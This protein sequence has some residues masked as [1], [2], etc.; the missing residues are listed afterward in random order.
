M[1]CGTGRWAVVVLVVCCFGATMGYA[2][3]ASFTN[4]A[5]D[6]A[7]GLSGYQRTPSERHAAYQAFMQQ[8]Q[9]TPFSVNQIVNTP[10]RHRGIPGV[11]IFDFDSDG[12]L[13]IYATNGPGTANS[14]FSNQLIESGTMR[15]VDVAAAAG[16][17]ATHQDST[18]V[19]YGDIDND[20]DHDLMVVGHTGTPKLF[21][22]N[23]GGFTDI[24]ATSG[25]TN[26]G[27]GM[28]CVMGDVDQDG[29]LD[30]FIARAYEL[31]TLTQCFGDVFSS[32]IRPN[33]L[34][35][36][37]GNGVFEDISDS[38]GIRDLESSGIPAGLNTLTWTGA[39]VDYDQDGD[40]DLLTTDDQ[41]NF[42][43]E[44]FGGFSRGYMQLFDNDGSGN[45]TNKT[46][47]AGLTL[48]SEWM[49]TA[50]GDFNHDGHLDFFATSFG[51]WG[52][53]FVG[54]PVTLGEESSRWYLGAEDG[55][56][57]DPGQG[58]LIYSPFGWGTVAE[59]FDNDGDTDVSFFGGLDLLTIV[60]KSN[61][62][63]YL[64]NDGDANFSYPPAALGDEHLRRNDSGAAAG[65]LNNDGLVD[66]VTVSNFNTP[67]PLPLVPFTVG[68]INYG[69][70]WDPA[71]FVPVADPG[72]AGFVWNGIAFPNGTMTLE[73]NTSAGANRSATV[74]VIGTKGLVAD[75][76]NN[77]D[78]IGAVLSFTP[79]GGETAIKPV[80]G[81]SSHM[82]QDSL[83][84]TFG[85]G[86]AKRGT[87]DILWPGGVKNRHY[88]IKAGSRHELPE[89]PYSYDSDMSRREYVQC[90]RWALRQLVREG[91]ITR[92]Q[93][94]KMLASAIRAR[95]EY[96]QGL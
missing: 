60:D 78:G 11:A 81:G 75:G 22:N 26:A 69:S 19:C 91:V 13:D 76:R 82:S 63:A 5:E 32:A 41:C 8:S 2:G 52:K 84:Q 95:R 1:G 49:G 45:F 35:R 23:G 71:F 67:A 27:A 50:W 14:L 39:L 56:F 79:K 17:E 4:V 53:Q 10:M 30:I 3:T 15:F 48:A 96:R 77:R 33:D 28:S 47:A 80:L 21:E 6:P 7:V 59:D 37:L 89:I 70:P 24:S 29:L 87:L 34:Y 9:V 72:P 93:A 88:G 51:E 20:G 58:D 90:V 62:G 25:V 83:A 36:N 42:P 65:D 40:L 66:I 18:G 43:T 61:P 46:I 57:T 12:D 68:G 94:G 16:V 92:S 73:L 54:A 85:L 44:T 86:H 31:E 38:S 74:S 55:T 64:E